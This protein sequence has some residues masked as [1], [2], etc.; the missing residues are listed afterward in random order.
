MF[1]TQP[2]LTK[3]IAQ[4]SR[5]YFT[6]IRNNNLSKRI[7]PDNDDMAALLTANIK[8]NLLQ[9]LDTLSSRNLG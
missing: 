1:N 8:T 7:I 2:N 5:R 6:V 9:G 4:C 3:D